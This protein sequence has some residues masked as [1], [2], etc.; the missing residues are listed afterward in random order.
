M[1]CM[2]SYESVVGDRLR[3]YDGDLQKLDLPDGAI[4]TPLHPKDRTPPSKWRFVLCSAQ[5]HPIVSFT[6]CDQVAPL[7]M[8]CLG[9]PVHGNGSFVSLWELGKKR[10]EMCV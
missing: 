5:A 7:V 10:G 6:T 3:V 4:D 9:G 8:S 2:Q 1:Y